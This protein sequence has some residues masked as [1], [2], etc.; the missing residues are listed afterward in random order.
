MRAID[1]AIDLIFGAGD[2][3]DLAAGS[4]DVR[5]TDVNSALRNSSLSK[6][7]G[8]KETPAVS[9]ANAY[10]AYSCNKRSTSQ[11]QEYNDSSGAA[12]GR[13]SRMGRGA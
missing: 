1:G 8:P 12:V 3:L 4:S 7:D 6:T 13:S 11:P 10:I 9:G 2:T 5:T